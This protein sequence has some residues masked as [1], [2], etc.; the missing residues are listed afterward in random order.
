[1][2]KNEGISTMM[3]TGMAAF[4]SVFAM[5]LLIVLRGAIGGGGG[6]EQAIQ[7]AEDR[8]TTISQQF[9][10]DAST[11]DINLYWDKVN[12]ALICV[13][14]DKFSV[15]WLDRPKEAIYRV[16]MAYSSTDLSSVEKAEE[17]QE[18]AK[19]IVNLPDKP[20]EGEDEYADVRA[21]KGSQQTLATGIY[22]FYVETSVENEAKMTLRIKYSDK[23]NKA[24]ILEKE[25]AQAY[26]DGA[27]AFR[28]AQ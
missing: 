1:M 26:S 8:A 11:A 20:S 3:V 27:K 16:A 13:S 15:T 6:N 5:V 22:A 4:I 2:K 7:E 28:A 25:Y 24:Q 23:E 14:S 9:T 21:A 19:Y 18:K 17:A 10:L 12:M